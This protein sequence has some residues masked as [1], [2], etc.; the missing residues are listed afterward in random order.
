[1]SHIGPPRLDDIPVLS[2]C[3][4]HENCEVRI[5]AAHTLQMLGRS[6][7]PAADAVETA[8]N[9]SLERYQ[10]MQRDAELNPE[11]R[12]ISPGR[13]H[14]AAEELLATL[15]HVTHDIS[16]FV[17]ALERLSIEAESGLYFYGFSAWD[18]DFTTEDCLQLESLLRSPNVHV[19]RSALT[20]ISGLGAIAAP[21]K[22]AVL[23]LAEADNGELSRE[24]TSALFAINS[25]A[26]DSL[27][28][29]ESVPLLLQKV[30]SGE[31]TIRE[32]ATVIAVTNQTSDEVQAILEYGIEHED[33]WTAQ[34]CA[35]AM[36]QVSAESEAGA[37]FV[38]DIARSGRVSDRNIIEI[39]RGTRAA[40]AT[41]IPYLASQL[42]NEDFWTRHDAAQALGDY[43]ADAQLLV[44]NLEELLIDEYDAVRLQ[45]AASIYRITGDP[46]HFE[47]EVQSVFAA[48]ENLHRYEALEMMIDLGPL[49]DPFLPYLMDELHTPKLLQ[50]YEV[51]DALISI[52]TPESLAAVEDAAQSTDWIRR[53]A[54]RTALDTLQSEEARDE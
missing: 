43:G 24:I 1:M 44:G 27:I 16:R 23:D 34:A 4:L 12:T 5:L 6:G 37:A 38:I 14:Y 49:A 2:E 42:S 29:D 51:I 20:A 8:L 41:V 18:D 19:Q 7:E 40:P 11:D 21:L 36:L 15:W 33:E 53:S 17:S 46:A 10:E 48:D 47:N 9:D 25:A 31:M 3:L 26:N 32:F 35:Q 30:R 45:A 28:A 13:W 54:A 52:G 39:L 22:E 50:P